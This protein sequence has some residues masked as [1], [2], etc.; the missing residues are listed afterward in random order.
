MKY[1]LETGSNPD[2]GSSKKR[3]SGP[4]IKAIDIHNFL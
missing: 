4:P 1:L 2:E 3:T